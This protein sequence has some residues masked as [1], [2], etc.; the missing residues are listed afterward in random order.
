MVGAS[1]RDSK[2]NSTTQAT[3]KRTRI[4]LEMKMKLITLYERG[5]GMS[6]IARDFSL[7]VST[8]NSI[9]KDADRIKEHVQRSAL[10]KS[11]IITKWR[12]VAIDEMEKLLIAWI[13][14]KMKSRIPLK[15]TAIQAKARHLYEKVKKEKCPDAPQTFMASNGW[16]NRFKNRAGFSFKNSGGYMVGDSKTNEMSSSL[17]EESVVNK[18]LFST[19]LNNKMKVRISLI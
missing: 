5:L 18:S 15:L 17:L 19:N 6:T 7:S 2:K 4:D 9:V 13:E 14:G 11:T 10:L 8:V 1:Q 3:R 16:F 12:A